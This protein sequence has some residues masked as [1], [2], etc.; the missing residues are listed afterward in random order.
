MKNSKVFL[1]LALGVMFWFIA[2]MI[3][4]F[5]GSYVFSENN[6]KLILFFIIAI[7]LTVVSMYITKLIGKLKFN[8]LLKPVAIMTIMATLLDGIA[9]AW[10]RQLYSQSF[11]IAFH[12]AAWILWG[13]GLGLL[14]AYLLE[15][16]TQKVKV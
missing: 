7:P 8:E 3:I 1:F 5:T 15:I 13:V 10:F 14:F 12:G 16:R 4:R 2:A 11:E 6:P 9:L